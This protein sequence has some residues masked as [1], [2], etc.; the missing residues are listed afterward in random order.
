MLELRPPGVQRICPFPPLHWSGGPGHRAE[1]ETTSRAKGTMGAGGS[2]GTHSS[3][4]E[5]QQPLPPTGYAPREHLRAWRLLR[6]VCDERGRTPAYG[7]AYRECAMREHHSDS[8]GPPC[9]KEKKRGVLTGRE[10]RSPIAPTGRVLEA[11]L[12]GWISV[13]CRTPIERWCP[14]AKGESEADLIARCRLS[15]CARRH[16]D[17]AHAHEP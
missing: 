13:T 11:S 3:W 5:V 8:R 10:V 14:C 17:D 6:P 1:R 12:A 16:R 4:S 7:I 9:W 15:A 2:A